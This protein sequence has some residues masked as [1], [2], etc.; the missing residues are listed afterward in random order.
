MEPLI[1]ECALNGPTLK[2]RNPNLPVAPDEIVNDALRCADAGVQLVHFHI[3]NLYL[4]GDVSAARYMESWERIAAARPDL[5]LCPTIPKGPTI[6]DR[7]EHAEV[8]VDKG[9]LT[10]APVDPGSINLAGRHPL[11]NGLPGPNSVV[12]TNSFSEIEY[13]L[14]RAE[15]LKLPVA[16][17]GYE[18]TFLRTAAAYMR[19]GKMPYG[20]FIKIYFGGEYCMSDGVKGGLSFGLRPTKKALE[21]Y[22][23]LVEGSGLLWAANVFGGDITETGMAR[24]AIDMGGHIRVGLEDYAGE[25]T[26]TNLELIEEIK[27]IAREV[28]RPLADQK[29]A[30]AM[31][32]ITR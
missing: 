20:G 5:I 8:L 13:V 22:V 11:P 25:R 10:L 12:Y 18:A 16:M 14:G 29:T 4:T 19:A 17:S 7:W 1:I 31:L 24:W 30:R 27:A 15:A 23:E 26:P 2:S 9:L 3:E 28:G 6:Q 32:G 21:A